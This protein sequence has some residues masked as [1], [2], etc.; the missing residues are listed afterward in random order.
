MAGSAA[1]RRARQQ[2]RRERRSAV[3]DPDIVLAAGAALLGIRSRT[4]HELRVRLVALGYPAGLVDVTVERL[5]ALGYLDDDGVC[6]GLGGRSRPE[7][8]HGAPRHFGRSCCARGSA[9][10]WWM[11]RSRNA[12]RTSATGPR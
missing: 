12:S 3:T 5:V 4:T 11:P 6:A 10:S 2:E 8:A 7:P 1:D 9:A